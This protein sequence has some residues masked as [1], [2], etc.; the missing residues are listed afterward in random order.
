MLSREKKLSWE[1]TTGGYS[2]GKRPFPKQLSFIEYFTVHKP[3]WVIVLNNYTLSLPYTMTAYLQGNYRASPGATTSLS[4]FNLC[5]A[6]SSP[7]TAYLRDLAQF[8]F[9]PI[10]CEFHQITVSSPSDNSLATCLQAYRS[11]LCSILCSASCSINFIC[12]Y[13]NNFLF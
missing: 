1:E 12:I 10:E 7:T 5:V 8:L 6:C 11:S 3:G 9:P 13:A 2:L 4:H